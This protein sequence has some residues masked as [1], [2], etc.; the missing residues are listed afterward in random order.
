MPEDSV[1]DEPQQ[2]WA[3]LRGDKMLFAHL[4]LPLVLSVPSARRPPRTTPARL[5]PPLGF[6]MA[7]GQ[8]HTMEP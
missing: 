4:T 7:P 2:H 8:H 6:S 3:Y 1:G 5:F